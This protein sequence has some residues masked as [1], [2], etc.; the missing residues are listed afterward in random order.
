MIR[1][2]L[3]IAVGAAAAVAVDRLI[4][5][6]SP[7]PA[8]GPVVARSDAAPGSPPLVWL[9]GTL[10]EIETRSVAVR[11]GEDGPVVELDRAA[12]GATRFF[13]LD[14]EEWSSVP[15]ED[16]GAEATGQRACVE[17]LLDGRTLLAL[18]VFVGA[19]CGPT[20]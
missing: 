14:D 7:D 2:I 11:E 20:G 18:R 6:P 15:E 1:G 12:A 16:I 4:L 19:G 3:L 5:T 10:E 8:G 9:D 13:R 17:A